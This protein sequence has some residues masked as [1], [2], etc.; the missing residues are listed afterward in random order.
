MSKSRDK[1]IC[2]KEC[3]RYFLHNMINKRNP[4]DKLFSAEVKIDSKKTTQENDRVT[5]YYTINFFSL[6]LC[7]L[8]LFK[9]YQIFSALY[10][11]SISKRSLL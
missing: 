7:L 6:S 1:N 5:Q 8:I 2:I 10:P 11:N 9:L 4:F 3:Y